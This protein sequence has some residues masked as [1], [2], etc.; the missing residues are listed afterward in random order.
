MPAFTSLIEELERALAVGTEAHR[1]DMLSRITDLFLAG[2]DRYSDGQIDLFDEIIGKLATA[3]EAK[4]RAKLASRLSDVPNAPVGVIRILAH[5]DDIEVAR[6]VLKNSDQLDDRD[7][8]AAAGSKGQ[9]HL[10]AIAQRRSLSEAVTDVLVERGNKYVAHS[11]AK[12]AGARF[13]DAGF[14]ILVKRS[15][16]D[17]A[18]ALHV[19][20][21]RDLPRQHF[22]TL[23]DQASATVRARLTTERPAASR[24]VEGVLNEVV[25]GIRSDTRKSSR[26][27]EAISEV[28]A[29]KRSGILGEAEVY[30]F[31]REGRFEETAVALSLLCGVEIDA[32][33]RALQDRGH[34]MT[35]ILAK[36]AGFSSTGAKSLLLLKTAGRG[37][38]AQD[39]NNALKS[40]GRLQVETAQRVL[41][42]YRARLKA[43]G[44]EAVAA[45]S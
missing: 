19:G 2:A 36:L 35:L 16:T 39:L 33:E 22:L 23:L 13:S 25:G 44:D 26:Y 43:R 11:I 37:I 40:Y 28:E 41:S 4:T 34:E 10:A 8:I 7:L 17:E 38:S 21:R 24:A 15:A 6:P 1:T 32:V 31:A 27:T 29:I 18:L 45:A 5:D 12:N 14:K 20:V 3:I 42:F 30:R 9:L